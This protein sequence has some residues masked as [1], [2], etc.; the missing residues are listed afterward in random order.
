MYSLG[1]SDYPSI[2][3]F[4][5]GYLYFRYVTIKALFICTGNNGISEVK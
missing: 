5:S 4:I 3:I 1:T 2:G